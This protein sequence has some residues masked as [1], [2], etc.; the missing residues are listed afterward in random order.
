[1]NPAVT[2]PCQPSTAR[3][4]LL[5][6][7]ACAIVLTAALGHATAGVVISELGTGAPGATLGGYTMTPF[8]DDGIGSF[9]DILSLASP[10]GGNLGFSNSVNTR[11][12]G[13]GWATWSHGYAGDVYFNLSQSLTIT[14]PNDVSAFYLYVESND[15]DLFDFTLTAQDGSTSTESV[16]GNAGAFG[17]GI[18]GTDGTELTSLTITASG[19]SGGFAV[20]EFGI[21][22]S[23]EVP[24]PASLALVGLALAALGVSRRRKTV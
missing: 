6:K 3:S 1:M 17:F 24:E 11:A 19:D 12:V 22:K 9:T 13:N 2:A 14:L 16:N 23:A 10:L 21:A 4:P 15:F 7:A 20:G 18:Y 8:G 5:I